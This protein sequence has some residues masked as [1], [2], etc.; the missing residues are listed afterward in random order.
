MPSWNLFAND[1]DLGLLADG[2]LLPNVINSQIIAPAL[3]TVTMP[4]RNTQFQSLFL[5][6]G[7]R[8]TLQESCRKR[9]SAIIVYT[10]L[11]QRAFRTEWASGLADRSCEIKK[12]VVVFHVV[13]G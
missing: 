12:A 1:L 9:T 7:Q 11:R 3:L 2:S 5:P 6:R 8:S 10:Y 4:W 13:S